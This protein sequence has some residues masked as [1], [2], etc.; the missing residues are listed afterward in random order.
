LTIYKEK[1]MADFRR[2]FIV[3]AVLALMAGAAS[4][5]IGFAGSASSSDT[6]SCTATASATQ[7]RQ[8][9]YTDL[10]GDI[11]IK[12]DGGAIHPAGVAGVTNYTT[13]QLAVQQLATTAITVYVSPS[14]PL[15]SRLLGTGGLS[16]ALLL[17]D[18]P[19][20]TLAT[21]AGSSYGPGAPQLLCSSPSLG[22]Q[23]GGCTQY[24]QQVLGSDGVTTYEIP[25]A[26]Y[27]GN[28]TQAANVF[29]GYVGKTGSQDINTVTFYGV[30][31]LPPSTTGIHREYRITN[32]RYP[33][34]GM[35]TG[36]QIQAYVSVGDSTVL[37]V[38]QTALT[39]AIV[40]APLKESVST[41]SNN[42][43]LQCH[44]VSASQ[45]ATITFT[46]GFA[47]MFKTRVVPLPVNNNDPQSTGAGQNIPGGLYGGVAQNSESGFIMPTATGTSGSTTYL[48]G[49]ADFGTRL[50]AVF[51]NVPVGVTLYVSTTQLGSSSAN[52]AAILVEVAQSSEAAIDKVTALSSPSPYPVPL[53]GQNGAAIWEVT[54]ANQASIDT[55]Q[56]GVYISYSPVAATATY[57]YGLPQ[58]SGMPGTLVNSV[59]LSFAPESTGGTFNTG[60]AE[61]LSMTTPIPRFSI[62]TPYSGLFTIVAQC[63]TTLLYPYV[64][65]NTSS[66]AGECRWSTG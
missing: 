49:L 5:Q 57:P 31:V 61:T 6:M 2:W 58:P 51:T 33:S 7:V 55:L 15:T 21:G 1:Q 53:T 30:P 34:V 43:Y 35:A 14:L 54:G 8:E 12:C 26:A 45:T 28:S 32:L 63:Q 41:T 37:P 62:L 27:S 47:S 38:P 59:A 65:H 24:A 22:A 9:G 42:T 50:K 29:Q 19:G 52:A 46:E 56:F 66:F 44:G 13:A 18:E 39:V 20:S 23:L 3:L 16:E 17:V 25:V 64:V 11:L 10:L 48:A 4:A 40:G 60:N 36:F